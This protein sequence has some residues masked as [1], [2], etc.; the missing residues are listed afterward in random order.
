MTAWRPRPGLPRPLVLL[1]LG[2]GAAA[3]HLA[4]LASPAE[5]EP[6]EPRLLPPRPPVV[7]LEERA[8]APPPEA[9]PVPEAEPSPPK[10]PK[11]APPATAPAPP[12][13]EAPSLREELDALATDPGAAR[14]AHAMF[15][16]GPERA[17]SLVFSMSD[18]E[19]LEV[20][21]S[22][23]EEFVAR[24]ERDDGL[25][26]RVD[27]ERESY[28]P[29]RGA[30]GRPGVVHEKDY[31]LFRSLPP[32]L[33]RLRDRILADPR[34][35]GG[36][37]FF[38]SRLSDLEMLLVARRTADALARRGRPEAFAALAAVKLRYRR[39]GEDYDIEVADLK[40]R[41]ETKEAQR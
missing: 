13:P 28:E 17:P 16:K 21:L 3:A 12:E 24:P 23:D 19:K 20:P 27:L 36:L 2:G 10:T 14:L 32:R 41:D 5:P 15:G 8:P 9:P 7:A 25:S 4:L 39:V 1:L 22:F 31:L 26:F 34:C 33:A 18:R 35:R 38:G 30:E 29:V 37:Y 6:S 11:P 40:F